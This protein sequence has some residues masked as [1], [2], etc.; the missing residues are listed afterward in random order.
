MLEQQT[1][2][3]I[4]IVASTFKLLESENILIAAVT[5]IATSTNTTVTATTTV[6]AM[7][8]RP[9]PQQQ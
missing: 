8:P 4:S 7:P 1:V 3:C 5:G 2:V 9:S 6:A